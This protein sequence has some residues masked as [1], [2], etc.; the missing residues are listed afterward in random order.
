MRNQLFTLTTM[1]VIF[2]VLVISTPRANSQSETPTA[3]ST[4]TP[5]PDFP[6][7]ATKVAN[8]P[9]DTVTSADKRVTLLIPKDALPADVTLSSVKINLVR[10]SD[11]PPEFLK[12]PPLANYSFEPDG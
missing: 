9:Y 10:S 12:T 7:E 5:I 1:L 3:E 11:L 4:V 8:G 2:S 6:A